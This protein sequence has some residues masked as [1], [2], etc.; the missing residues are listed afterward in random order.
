MRAFVTGISGF[1]GGHLTEHLLASG[2]LVVGVSTSGRFPADLAHLAGSARVEP[3][4]LAADDSTALAD[5]IARKRP[6]TIYHLAAQSNPRA[7]F[8]DP[9][10]TWALNL[11]GTLNLLLAV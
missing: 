2:D 6:E 5:A 1:V 7:S 4:D 11:G 3:M 10:G 8:D 9:R